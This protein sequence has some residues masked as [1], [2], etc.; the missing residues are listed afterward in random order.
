MGGMHLV[1]LGA[2]ASIASSMRN[3]ERLG[4]KLPSMNDLPKVIDML[5]I[6]CQLPIE[7]ICE[8][9][10]GVY[11]N[12]YEWDSA[13]KYLKEINDRIYAYF[14][15]LQLSL[16]PTIYDYLMMSLIDKDVIVSG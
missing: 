2:G 4:R 16:Q 6:L 11:G 15:G 13:S 12:I 5:D 14:E 9:F 1:V 7:L 10:E 8:N 3:P